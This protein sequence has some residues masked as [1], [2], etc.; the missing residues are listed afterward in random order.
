MNARVLTIL[1]TVLTACLPRTSAATLAELMRGAPPEDIVYA[2]RAGERLV[3][4]TFRPADAAPGERRPA[5]LWIHG[6]AWVGGTTDGFMPLARYCASRGLVAFNVTY[7]LAKPGSVTVA[8][9]VAD[10]RSALRYV[11]AHAAE[12]GVDPA[13]IAVAGDSAGGHLAATLGTDTGP[14]HPD[15]APAVSGRANALLL[16]N[17]IVDMTEA[18]WIRYAVGG[19]ALAD[20]KNTPR[21]AAPEDVALARSLSPLFDVVPG[22]PPALLLHGRAD[23]IVPI[24]QAERF[25]AAYRAAGNRIDF[26]VVEGGVGHAFVIPGY[27]WPEPVVV[28]AVRAADAFL[29]SV[30]WISGEPTLTVSSPPAWSVPSPAR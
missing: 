20:K 16:F 27:K 15:D 9:C 22:Q 12:L 10:C 11:R 18:D 13:R 26:T 2:D 28:E 24:S 4:H 25:A 6:G 1:F 29:A 7:R 30:G 8:D 19:P 5:I 14:S 17:P 3:V 21:P 23:R